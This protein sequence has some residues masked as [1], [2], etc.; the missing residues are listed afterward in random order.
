MLALLPIALPAVFFFV[1]FVV[2]GF[3]F[4]DKDQPAVIQTKDVGEYHVTLNGAKSWDNYCTLYNLAIKNRGGSVINTFDLQNKSAGPCTHDESIWI[5]AEDYNH[6]THPDIKLL[7]DNANKYYQIY[8]YDAPA[9]QFVV[10]TESNTPAS[11]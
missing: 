2:R 11:Q 5:H 6:D 3:S 7:T 8:L 10:G 1:V 4:D 9:K